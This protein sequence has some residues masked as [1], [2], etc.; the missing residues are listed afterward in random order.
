MNLGCLLW[1]FGGDLLSSLLPLDLKLL[2]SIKEGE[3]LLFVKFDRD[4]GLQ[5]FLPLNGSLFEL[6]IR[7]S[8][9]FFLHPVETVPLIGI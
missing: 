4:C 3:N 2:S 5:W 1:N 6:C 8:M 9:P 7:P